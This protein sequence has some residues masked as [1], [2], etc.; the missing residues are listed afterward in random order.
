MKYESFAAVLLLNHYLV[1][2]CNNFEYE[3]RIYCIKNEKMTVESIGIGI[4][5]SSLL[6]L[7]NHSCDPNAIT[8]ANKNNNVIFNGRPINTG[9]QVS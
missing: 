4:G 1:L 6:S 7:V 5:L 3:E 8:F 2:Q 9:E